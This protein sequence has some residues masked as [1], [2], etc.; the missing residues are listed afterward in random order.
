MAK[1]FGVSIGIRGRLLL[2]LLM[3]VVPGLIVGVLNTINIYDRDLHVARKGMRSVLVHARHAYDDV[4]A[5]TEPDL[6]LAVEGMMASN[7]TCPVAL[8]NLLRNPEYSDVGIASADGKILCSLTRPGSSRTTITTALIDR[9]LKHNGR[10]MAAVVNAHNAGQSRVVLL[11]ALESGSTPARVVYAA[12]PFSILPTV[13]VDLADLQV[14]ALTIDANGYRE[15]VSSNA[16][17]VSDLPGLPDDAS[18]KKIAR[19]ALVDGL[20]LQHVG[21][22][23]LG[24][25]PLGARGQ[26]GVIALIIPNKVLY[27]TAED[28]LR[29]NL[30]V[31]ALGLIF[32]VLVIWT[33]SKRLLIL[34]A[35]RL[36][37]TAV[38]LASGDWGAR[39]GLGAGKG[40]FSILAAAFDHMAAEIDKKITENAI[41]QV[42][43]ARSDRLHAV[44]AA[45]NAAI[46]R[47]DSRQQLLQAICQIVCEVGDFNRAWIGEIDPVAQVLKPVSWVG[48]LSTEEVHATLTLPLQTDTPLGHGPAATAARTGVAVAVNRFQEDPRTTP[49]HD[50]ARKFDVRSGASIPMGND[51][52]DHHYVLSVYSAE[53]D[54]FGPEEVELLTQ[55]AQ[56]AAF[57]LHLIDTEQAL[58]HAA[59]VDAATGLPHQQTVVQQLQQAIDESPDQQL[60]I[61]VVDVE[62]HRIASEWGAAAGSALLQQVAPEIARVG[63]APDRAGV[64][65]GARF[66]LIFRKADSQD[67]IR[68]RLISLLERLSRIRI[69]TEHGLVNVSPKVGVALFPRDGRLAEGLIDKALAALDQVQ[70][71]KNLSLLFYAPEF[72]VA[73]QESRKLELLLQGAIARREL[74]VHYQPILSLKTGA[75]SGFEAL[76]RWHHPTLGSISPDRFIPLAER[77]GLILPIGDWIVEQVARQAADWDHLA[78]NSLFIAI[79]VSA[80]QLQDEHFAERVGRIVSAPGLTSS[81]IRLALEVTETHVMTDIDRSVVLL[82]QM[83]DLGMAIILDDFGTGYSSLS[84][85]QRLPVDVLKIDKLFVEQIDGKAQDRTLVE[86]IVALSRSLGLV[87]VVEGI[88]R[89]EQLSVVEELGCTYGQGFLFA[90][91]QTADEARRQ[92]LQPRRLAGD[93][94]LASTAW[95]YRAQTRTAAEAADLPRKSLRD[96]RSGGEVEQV[97]P[98]RHLMAV[99]TPFQ[100]AELILAKA[101]TW[102]H[103]VKVSLLWG[104]GETPP[105]G[106]PVAPDEAAW[107]QDALVGEGYCVA[108]G[109]R[110]VAWRV[111]P[112]ENIVLLLHFSKARRLST[113][114]VMIESGLDLYCQQL[115]LMVEMSTLRQSHKKVQHA[116]HVQRALAAI[117]DLVGTHRDLPEMLCRIQDIIGSLMYAENFYVVR[118]DSRRHTIRVLHFVD[119]V[120]PDEWDR[121]AD[122][123]LEQWRGSLTHVVLRTNKPLMGNT[124]ALRTGLVGITGHTDSA[125]SFGAESVQWLGVPMQR[126]GQVLGAVVVQSYREDKVYTNDDR[127]VLEF[128]ASHILSALDRQQSKVDLEQHVQLRTQELTEANRHLQSEIQERQRTATLQ[129]ALFQLAQLATDDMDEAAFYARVHALVSTLLH[130]ENFYIALVDERAGALVFPYK[131]DVHGEM[132]IDR[133]QGLGL[134]EHVIHH[135]ALLV[136]K[137]GMLRMIQQGVL[138]A[139][140]VGTPAACWLGVPLQIDDQVIG[141]TAVQCYEDGECFTAK[142]Q[143]LL[144]FVASQIAH[145]IHRRRT[146]ASLRQ[147]MLQLEERVEERTQE[148]RLQMEERQLMQQQLEYQ[149]LHDPLT[150]LPNRGALHDRLSRVLRIMQRDP[151]RRCALL[152]LDVDRFKSV[153]DRFG[154]RAGDEFLNEIARRIQ[155]CLREP[156]MV[157]RLS[158]DEFAIL[159]E[160]IESPDTAAGVA[161]RVLRALNEPLQTAGETLRPTASIGIAIGDH[162]SSNSD[163]VVHEADVALY[164]AKE[165]G[166]NRYEISDHDE[167]AIPR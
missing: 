167:P 1:L 3:A 2:L 132:Y 133:P 30:L 34:P 21:R 79:N 83:R 154:H 59:Q 146:V 99:T 116:A 111:L 106:K 121:S 39:A 51:W 85:L 58:T 53:A 127:E 35:R 161:R 7:D 12:S 138:D 104:D 109:G 157:A 78:R 63:Q 40:E 45:I 122:I 64:L 134:S 147:T 43:L 100:V 89:S 46:V 73:Q 80:V 77:T 17:W 8:H 135:G 37:K 14:T 69:S 50:F 81:F 28:E 31:M 128:V 87:T 22:D 166:R 118:L 41:Q 141:M 26:D 117:S 23:L 61:C 159:V 131:Q 66:A 113:L 96:P 149:V 47:R 140:A 88:E 93:G 94:F 60:A 137:E 123:P 71:E 115:R 160:D 29:R 153:N 163:N 16:G 84:Y 68:R 102:P 13:N 165:R 49:W 74:S 110:R 143:E 101:A 82:T 129:T 98:L 56:D 164:K 57:G 55:L 155:A 139:D 126:D 70:L 5:H 112:D 107:A 48:P 95:E 120:D 86:G 62:F 20:S 36:T 52:P 18:N 10:A 124:A 162:R 92:W 42:K 24:V 27:A 142:D 136:D 158:G 119:T 76:L 19:L 145:S 152:Y 6:A 4:V 15:T 33:A 44:L 148:L 9:A 144:A 75:L 114:R 105:S 151:A 103:C 156:D 67:V 125:R 150:G 38:R 32:V 91:A 65:A 25:L 130:T 54:F 11:Q 97:D 72:H 108:D 90:R